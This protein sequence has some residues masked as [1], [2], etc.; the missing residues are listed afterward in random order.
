MFLT[1]RPVMTYRSLKSPGKKEE[2]CHR[3]FIEISLYDRYR[4][5]LMPFQRHSSDVISREIKR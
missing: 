1:H 5:I 4:N 3:H 2:D